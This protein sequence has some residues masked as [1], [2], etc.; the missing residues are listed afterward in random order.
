MAKFTTADGDVGR[1]PVAKLDME[2][3][4]I[5]NVEDPTNDQDVATKK[6]VKTSAV[7][8]VIDGGGSAITTGIKGDILIPFA[9]TIT[10][11]SLLADQSG[12]IVLDLWKDTYAN[13]PPTVADTIT[14]SAKPTITSAT[15]SQDSTLTGWTT[16][17]AAGDILRINVDSVTSITR[18]TL[19]LK[20]TRS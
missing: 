15:K 4:A 13:S 3:K 16:S 12:S 2:T 7:S 1:A 20:V 9:C 17:V 6:F 14:A 10:Q 19:A 8:F 18:C 11:A 5:I